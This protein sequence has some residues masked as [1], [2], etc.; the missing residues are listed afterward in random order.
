[1][2][3]KTII[4][5]LLVAQLYG[6]VAS[7][8]EVVISSARLHSLSGTEVTTLLEAGAIQLRG[9]QAFLNLQ[10]LNTLLRHQEQVVALAKDAN[11]MS[12]RF[13]PY[14]HTDDLLRAQHEEIAKELSVRYVPYGNT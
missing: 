10:K 1:M 3:K 14:G 4:S 6:Q 13:V 2:N 7:A 5:L 12:S 8:N 11:A 9:E